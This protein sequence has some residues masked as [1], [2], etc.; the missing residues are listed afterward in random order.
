[1]RVFVAVSLNVRWT[2]GA[3]APDESRTMP[4]TLPTGD[5]IRFAAAIRTSGAQKINFAA[6]R[7]TI[8]PLDGTQPGA[9]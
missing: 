7:L 2:S 3:T 4:E 9:P 8:H 6:L 1:M 5:A